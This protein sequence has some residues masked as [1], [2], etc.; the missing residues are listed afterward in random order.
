VA[1]QV[2]A[3][4]HG[5][6]HSRREAPE[7]GA[8]RAHAGDE[9]VLRRGGHVQEEHVIAQG[10]CATAGGTGDARRGGGRTFIQG[11][12]GC[13]LLHGPGWLWFAPRSWMVTQSRLKASR[14]D[15][16]RCS[17]LVVFLVDHV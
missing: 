15:S 10:G 1:I 11:V 8:W 13:G 7:T 9:E 2:V 4:T 17:C 16:Y 12:I 5:E 3:A 6:E 14:L